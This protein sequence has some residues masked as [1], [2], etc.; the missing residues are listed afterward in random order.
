MRKYFLIILVLFSY[1]NNVFIEINAKT[2]NNTEQINDKKPFNEYLL[3][4]G[5]VLDIIIENLEEISGKYKILNDGSIFMPL[6][7][8]INLNNLS[9]EEAQKKIKY[10]LGKELISPIVYM[11]IIATRPVKV[12]VIGEIN[13][14]GVYTLNTEKSIEP[15][16]VDIDKNTG[17][18][19]VSTAIQEAGGITPETDLSRIIL[20]RRLSG[21]DEIYN[22]IELNFLDLFLKGDQS[23]NPILY[24][25]DVVTLIKADKKNQ[26]LVE[27]Y[28]LNLSPSEIRINIIGAVNNP[29][30]ITVPSNTTL[31]QA[32][33]FAGGPTNWKANTG[34]VRLVRINPNG[35]ASH[36]KYKI[37]FNANV[38]SKQNPNLISGDTVYVYRSLF[39]KTID[40]LSMIAT[41]FKDGLTIYSLLKILD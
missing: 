41:P 14:A 38:S 36:K 19:T 7:G 17:M 11:K 21:K 18:P 9:L 34:N 35:T 8:S 32:L 40:G 30:L 3:G 20:K 10:Q 23:Q 37:N 26:N 29:G 4:E 12:A 1:F 31:N 24:D 2:S 6:I 15:G 5:D 16:E 25:G 13:R 28:S 27:P 39:G 33:L 22:N